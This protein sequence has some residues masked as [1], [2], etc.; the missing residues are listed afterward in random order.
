MLDY[1][2]G[3]A[4]MSPGF[5]TVTSPKEKSQCLDR[6][7]KSRINLV[8]PDR[9]CAEWLMRNGALIKWTHSNNYIRHYN[10]LPLNEED[11]GNYL[12]KEVDATNSGIAYFG[13]QHF[14]G[15]KYVDKIKFNKC[16]YIDDR[17]LKLLHILKYS[18]EDLE[19]NE[20]DDVTVEGLKSLKQLEK[21]RRLK[22]GE[23]S[24][25]TGLDEAARELKNSL[26]R[27]IVIA[28]NKRILKEEVNQ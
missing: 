22:L 24:G 16:Q 2:T 13:F 17:A 20:C 3:K 12:L 14:V 21:L 4:I 15:C 7:S 1:C 8:G 23:L 6:V 19:I 5:G 26:P 28:K 9:A 27:C 10:N 11:K 25:V 18:L